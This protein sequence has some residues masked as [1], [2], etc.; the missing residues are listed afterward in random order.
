MMRAMARRPHD[1]PTAP[2]PAVRNLE[3]VELGRA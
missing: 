1:T 3:L 2:D